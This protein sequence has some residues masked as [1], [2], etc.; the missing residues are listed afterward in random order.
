M[1]DLKT[2]PTGQSV[3]AF[4]ETIEDEQ[5][6]Q[7]S[8]A[9]LE[10]MR[11]AT[12]QAPKMWGESMIGF[13]DLHY[14]YA[15]GREGDIFRVGF[16]PRKNNLTLYLTYGFEQH[17]DLMARLGKYKTGKAC[18]YIKKLAEIDPE[19]LRQL[20]ERAFLQQEQYNQ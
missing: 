9:V 15:T 20:V 10:I 7:D 2:Q 8:Y 18:L 5:K 19:V 6:R 1:A 16:S 12:R 17:N 3:T 11:Q 14:K 13:G 4:L